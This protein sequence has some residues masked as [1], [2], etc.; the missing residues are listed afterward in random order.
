MKNVSVQKLFNEIQRQTNLYFLFN[1]EQISRLGKVSVEARGE[2]VET[3][4][5]SVFKD[6]ELTYVFDKN[7]IIVRLQ[8]TKD[9]KK[10]KTVTIRGKVCDEK[11][12]PLPGVTVMLKGFTLGTAT[13][14][15]GTYLLQIPNAPEKFSLLFS[16]IGMESREIE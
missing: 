11:K 16:F 9:D 3:V 14:K 12:Q 13:T 6:A 4:L 15:E 5:T 1:I 7:M 2:T 10:V 8:N